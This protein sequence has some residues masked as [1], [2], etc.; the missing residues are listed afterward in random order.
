MQLQKRNFVRHGDI[1]NWLTSEAFDLKEN[2]Q[3]SRRRSKCLAL[4]GEHVAK[5]AEYVQNYEGKKIKL[6]YLERRA[7]FIARE[8]R[9][10]GRLNNGDL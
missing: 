8:L 4:T 9:R 5:L 1:S 10:Q 7:P 6:E 2:A 3:R